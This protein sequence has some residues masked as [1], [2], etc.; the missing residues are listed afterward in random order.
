MRIL[1]MRSIRRLS[2]KTLANGIRD[3]QRCGLQKNTPASAAAV[4]DRMT[5]HS[6]SKAQ[7]VRSTATES[8]ASAAAIRRSRQCRK[9]RSAQSVT[10]AWWNAGVATGDGRTRFCEDE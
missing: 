4:G 8:A 1:S 5:H 7:Q 3:T 9:L 2:W 10:W 6:D